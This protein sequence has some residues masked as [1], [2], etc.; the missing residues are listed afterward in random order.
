MIDIKEERLTVEEIEN[1]ERLFQKEG[2]RFLG[3]RGKDRVFTRFVNTPIEY[4]NDF[5]GKTV[6]FP[7]VAINFRFFESSGD[8]DQL[9]IESIKFSFQFYIAYDLR[10][11]PNSDRYEEMVIKRGL[12]KNFE[13]F[14]KRTRTIIRFKNPKIYNNGNFGGHFYNKN[15]LVKAITSL[16]KLRREFINQFKGSD[17]KKTVTG[18]K[19][20]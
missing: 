9:D 18:R 15:D 20:L 2:Y 10:K 16:D 13:S 1:L 4:G 19:R 17:P 3:E 6:V 5:S 14:I 7:A 11:Y 8:M 12:R